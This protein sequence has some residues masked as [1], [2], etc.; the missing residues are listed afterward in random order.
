VQKLGRVALFLL[1]GLIV[2]VAALVLGLNLYVQSQGTQARIEQEVRDRLG[3][4]LTIQ[5]ISVTPWGG[6][7]LGEITIPQTSGGGSSNLF[8]A[9]T[10]R[11]RVG[12]L[13]LFSNKLLIKRV[14]VLDAKVVWTQNAGG[15]WKLPGSSEVTNRHLEPNEAEISRPETT[16]RS[17]ERAVT[18]EPSST[19]ARTAAGESKAG[20]IVPE[21]RRVD[22]SRADFRFLDRSGNL[23]AA[24]ESVGFHSNLRG[25]AELHGT[26]R[27]SK[28]SLRDRFFLEDLKSPLEYD[29]SRLVLTQVSAHSGGGNISGRF[30]IEP[31]AEDSPFDVEIKFRNVEADRIVGDAGG[32]LGVVQGKLE[33]NFQAAGKTADANM[34]TGDGEIVLRDG[35]VKQYS[36]LVA[37]GQVFQ[38]EELTQLH[39]EQAQ[40]KYHITPGLVNVDEL[41][42]NSQNIRL[43]AKGTV[44]FGGKLHLD[45]RLAINEKIR[46]QLF[47][48]IR[49]NFQP[50]N[51]PGFSAV[52]FEVGG[53]IDRPKTNLLEKV[54][55]RDL[56]DLVNSLWGGKTSRSKKKQAE[57]EPEG[58]AVSP[59]PSASPPVIA[60]P[61]PAGSP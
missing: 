52:E 2:L 33:G 1:G 43:S 4:P 11:L 31:E 58:P 24:F 3:V 17:P 13:S 47:K 6:L 21:V 34:L 22:L 10:L 48:P 25:V 57:S 18:V 35:Q 5:S 37:L 14:S 45:S 44:T 36:L 19:S 8:E 41:T 7:K 54:V 9:K 27:V 12:L 39:L 49:V 38:I 29:G 32:P 15:K 40:A 50:T 61:T 28:I 20:R 53:T 56:K 46:S 51:E 55:G 30:S 16:G 59:S 42:L 23:V 60:A 26:T